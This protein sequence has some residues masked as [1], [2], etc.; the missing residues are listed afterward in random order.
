[1][2][3]KRQMD[4]KRNKTSFLSQC[5]E[6]A[7][8]D[9]QLDFIHRFAALSLFAG[10]ADTASITQSARTPFS[11]ILIDSISSHDILFGHDGISRRTAEGPGRD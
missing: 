11:N 6:S 1:M 7:Q 8:N 2:F 10:G 3:T 5:I 9:P 4:E